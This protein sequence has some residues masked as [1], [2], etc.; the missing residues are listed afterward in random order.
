MDNV[1][2]LNKKFI[3]EMKFNRFFMQRI[4]P[5]YRHL[6]K[7]K[8]SERCEVCTISSR[9]APLQDGQCAACGLHKEVPA[10]VN[11]S[12]QQELHQTLLSAQGKGKGLYDALVFFSGGKDS[13]YMVKTLQ[14]N[15]KELRIL[16]FTVDNGFNS[17][18]GEENISKVC[19][20]HEIEHLQIRP[21]KIFSKLYRFGF[22][23]FSHRGFFAT[24][25][26]GGELFQDIG[27]NIAAQM[28]IPLMLLGYTPQQIAL[29]DPDYHG[30]NLYDPNRAIMKDSQN[31]TRTQYL[32]K[33]LREAFS[34]S[35][36]KYWWDASKY[37]A[38]DIPTMIFP[39]NAWG[40]DK[41]AIIE[42]AGKFAVASETDPMLTN[43]LYCI[44]GIYLD[45]QILGYCSFE[46]EWATYVREKIADKNYNRSTWEVNEYFNANYPNMIKK[47]TGLNIVLKKLGMTLEELDA[48]VERSTAKLRLVSA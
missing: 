42:E 24:D 11:K 44:P 14:E 27:R 16:A 32:G 45:Y 21:Y 2:V 4:W 18:L 7:Q 9:Y 36:M 19:K 43:H 25:A 33:D 47:N 23:N 1:E 6:V 41:K 12:Q 39:F 5:V 35:E 48:I 31:F 40:Y 15:Y 17:P 30:H 10:R 3:S 26:F 37:D 46:P 29:I 8:M 20:Q 13:I 28:K 22:E 38:D 34:D